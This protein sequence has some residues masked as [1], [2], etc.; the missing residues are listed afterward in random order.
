MAVL[1]FLEDKGDLYVKCSDLIE[2]LTDIEN[3]KRLYSETDRK[4]ASE[5]K[6]GLVKSMNRQ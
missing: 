2:F 3:N 6:E 5:I 1:N 4:L